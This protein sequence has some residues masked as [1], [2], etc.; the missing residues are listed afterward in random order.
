MKSWLINEDFAGAV[1]MWLDGKSKTPLWD[2]EIDICLEY[3]MIV[4][5]VRNG[6]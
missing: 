1:E 6:W 4:I 3:W 2:K 5:G